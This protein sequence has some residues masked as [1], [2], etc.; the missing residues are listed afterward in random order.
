MKQANSK[1]PS[2]LI[3][4][5]PAAFRALEE[6][7]K[8]W[9]IKNELKR[10]RIPNP[11]TSENRLFWARVERSEYDLLV[12]ASELFKTKRAKNRTAS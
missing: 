2:G 3:E 11:G 6:L 1:I 10:S 9:K 12:A 4:N 7:R 5:Y 8:W